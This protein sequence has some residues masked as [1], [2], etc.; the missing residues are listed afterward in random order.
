MADVQKIELTS[1]GLK[2][3]IALSVITILC[4]GVLL[5]YGATTPEPV[6]KIAAL[7]VALIGVNWYIVTRIRIWWNHK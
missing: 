4:G 6:V 7:I 5:I 1:K 3:Q 2:A